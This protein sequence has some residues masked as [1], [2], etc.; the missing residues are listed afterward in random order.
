MFGEEKITLFCVMCFLYVYVYVS[1]TLS[2]ELC[3]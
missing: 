2:A 1:P 3:Q